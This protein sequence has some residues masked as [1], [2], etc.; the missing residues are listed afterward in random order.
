MNITIIWGKIISIPFIIKFGLRKQYFNL[1]TSWT[2]PVKRKEKKKK[3]CKNFI[4]FKIKL[5]LRKT[6]IIQNYEHID[7]LLYKIIIT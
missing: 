5:E 3:N 1:D 4:I 6:L 2:H 7:L